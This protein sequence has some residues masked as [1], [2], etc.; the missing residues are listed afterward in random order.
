[1]SAQVIELLCWL[2]LPSVPTSR[3]SQVQVLFRP[4]RIRD[5]RPRGVRKQDPAK[6]KP[7]RATCVESPDDLDRQPCARTWPV[8]SCW[9]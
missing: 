9:G 4:R 2:P 3:M 1:M 6:I 8:C 7:I 5:L